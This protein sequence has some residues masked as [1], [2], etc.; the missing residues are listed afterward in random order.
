MVA[1]KKE[2]FRRLGTESALSGVQVSYTWRRDFGREVLYGGR[3]RVDHQL[4]AMRGSQPRLP[5]DEQ[6]TLFAFIQVRNLH[7]DPIAADE[8]VMEI[9]TVV[10]ELLAGDPTLAGFADLLFAGVAGAELIAP[11]FDDDGVTSA[12]AVEIGYRSRLS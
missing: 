5:R 8:R 7:S 2:L 12:M 10:E 9:A 6:V 11:E 4:A 3:A 1:V